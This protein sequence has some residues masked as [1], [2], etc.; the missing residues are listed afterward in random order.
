MNNW[1]RVSIG[2]EP[3]VARFVAAF[4]ELFPSG[5]I[6]AKAETGI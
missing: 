3:E 4:K 1:L 5:G 2:T 6:K